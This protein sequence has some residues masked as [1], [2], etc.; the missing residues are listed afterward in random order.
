M[1]GVSEAEVGANAQRLDRGTVQQDRRNGSLRHAWVARGS[2]DRGWPRQS[3]A[4][5]RAAATASHTRFCLGSRLAHYSRW[6]VVG[7]GVPDVAELQSRWVSLPS[8]LK[9]DRR[10]LLG[11]L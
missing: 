1:N 9:Q 3:R 8:A 10:P 2:A 6:H 5:S 4:Q 7:E 11:L